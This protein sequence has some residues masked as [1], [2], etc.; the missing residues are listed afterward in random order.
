MKIDRNKLEQQAVWCSA[1]ELV[2][3]KA[4]RDSIK[5]KQ[6]EYLSE[7][8]G[9]EFEGII[10]DNFGNWREGQEVSKELGIT[11]YEAPDVYEANPTSGMRKT[12]RKKLNPNFFKYCDI[13][14]AKNYPD[15]FST[16]DEIVITEKIHGANFR[17][18]WLKRK[19]TNWF[20]ALWGKLFGEYEFVY[21]SRTVQ[22][23]SNNNYKGFYGEDVYGR[24]A[25]KNEMKR[26]C[27]LY[28]DYE[29]FGEVYGPK[30]QDLTYDKKEIDLIFFDIKDTK[31]ERYLNVDEFNDIMYK[32]FLPAVPILYRGKFN[33]DL[34]LKFATGTS[35]LAPKQIKEGVVVKT[36]VEKPSK[37]GRTLAKFI[38]P[39]YYT[40]ENGTENK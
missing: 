6:A 17:C 18:G 34:V 15:L 10:L 21:G 35:A 19:N 12:S 33:K 26:W 13:E 28:P 16:D 2:A 39:S 25:E 24:A 1:R 4:E 37:I 9:T 22:I 20:D 30:I 36:V 29:F 7:R 8:I 27:Q 5:Y 31:T 11:K 23:S 32:L 14:N 3:S 40:R 38:N